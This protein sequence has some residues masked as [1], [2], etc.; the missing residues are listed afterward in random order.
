MRSSALKTVRVLLALLFFI[1]ITLY[2]C[3]FAGIFPNSFHWL[4][5][6]QVIPA[7]LAGSV[8]LLIALALL[9]VLWGRVYCSTICPLGIMQD[10]ISRISGRGKKKNKKKCWFRYA[11]PQHYLRYGLLGI[12]V[13][14]FVMGI[15][16]PLSFLDPYSNFGRVAANLFRP[17]VI[18]FNNLIHL[19]AVKAGNFDFY[20]VSIYTVTKGSLISGL[21]VFFIVGTMALLRGRLFCNTLCPVGSLLGLISRFSMFRIVMDQTRCNQCTL[22]ER[23]CKSQCIDSQNGTIDASRCVSCYNCLS[24]CKQKAIDYRFTWKKSLQESQTT[25]QPEQTQTN[26]K[27]SIQAG[28]RDFIATGA[29]IATAVP[30]VHMWAQRTQGDTSNDIPIT[31][32][33]SKSLLHFKEKC[34]GC[35][36]CVTH[37]PQQILKPAG[38]AF[39]FDYLLKPH[40]VYE[41]AYCSYE[42]DICSTVCPNGAIV[43]FKSPDDKKITQIGV[44]RFRRGRCVVFNDETDCGACAEHC[45]TQA[46]RMVPYKDSLRIP[47]VTP[48]LC[49]GCGGCEYICPVRPYR[50]I[51]VIP[52]EVHEMAEKPKVEEVK[53]F[54]VDDFGF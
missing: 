5:Q 31:P 50:A 16:T 44:A 47:E 1:P 30:L 38:L 32:P 52:N 8:G 45:P 9:T 48:E 29:M 24:R 46:V 51:Y 15:V 6:I 53:D 40:M 28:R 26:K 25:P 33:G 10:F 34:T 42:C 13:I 20:H 3:D 12:C 11:K 35:H 7:I 23:A 14:L 2:F 19:V 54:K 36:L 41:R 39:G 43:P 18:G 37:C 21:I 17:L 22:C 4:L 27:E 49:V